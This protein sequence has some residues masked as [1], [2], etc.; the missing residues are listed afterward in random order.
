MNATLIDVDTTPWPGDC[1]IY[2]L[3]EPYEG[4]TH[5]AVSVFGENEVTVTYVLPTTAAGAQVPNEAGALYALTE[6][7]QTTHADALAAIGYTEETTP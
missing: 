1:Q 4:W 2:E 6:L 3:P 7:P 5:I